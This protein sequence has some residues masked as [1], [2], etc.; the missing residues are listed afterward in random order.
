[1]KIFR[2]LAVTALLALAAVVIN[3][4]SA[5]AIPIGCTQARQQCAIVP[6]GE[7]MFDGAYCGE[8]ENGYVI[9]HLYHCHRD[10]NDDWGG[11]ECWEDGGS[12]PEQCQP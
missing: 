3:T 7:V 1:M 11:G 5:Q 9:V 4:Q 12:F 6:G 10:P 2:N 8:N